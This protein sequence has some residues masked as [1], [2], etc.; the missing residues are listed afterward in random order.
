M[1]GSD[2][3]DPSCPPA[4]RRSA[5]DPDTGPASRDTRCSSCRLL[6]LADDSR[7]PGVIL[8]GLLELLPGPVK[9][10]HHRPD[11]HAKHLRCILVREPLNVDQQHHLT[12]KLGKPLYPPP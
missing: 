1:A 11:R 7:F 12:M 6:L 8:E 9:S 3:R 5:P 10:R 4:P 2:R